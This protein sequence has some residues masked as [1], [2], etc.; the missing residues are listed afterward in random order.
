M[1]ELLAV[2]GIMSI[3]IVASMASIQGLSKGSNITAGG[4]QIVDLAAL[5]RQNASTR[6][7]KTALVVVKDTS[8]DSGKGASDPKVALR[9]FCVMEYDVKTTPPA[10]KMTTP[11]QSMPQSTKIDVNSSFLNSLGSTTP[12]TSAK[13]QGVTY[14]QSQL[15]YQIFM[16]DGSVESGGATPEVIRVVSERGGTD[17]YYD[18]YL[19]NFT[20]STKVMRPEDN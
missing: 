2:V 15:G 20:G 1:V 8:I 7:V 11:W 4:N 6:N 5:A 16:P 13:R 14:G 9:T 10:W 19:N 3:L 17:N 12:I 18:I